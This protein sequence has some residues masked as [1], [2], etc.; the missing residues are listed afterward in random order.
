MVA[1]TVTPSVAAG[2]IGSIRVIAVAF[3][4][5]WSHAAS[6]CGKGRD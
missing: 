5:Q 4:H 2:V 6:Q 1:A 3:V